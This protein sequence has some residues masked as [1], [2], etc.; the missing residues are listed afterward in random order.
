MGAKKYLGV[1]Y[2][3]LG[4]GLFMFTRLSNLVPFIGIAILIAPIFILRFIRTQPSKRGIW[5]TIL[6]FILSFNI[7]LWGLFE[8]DEKWMTIVFGLIRS[9]LLATIWFLPFIMDRMIYPRFKKRGAF[10]TLVF[11]VITTAIFYLS[12]LEG[13]FDDGSG[14]FSS[15][16]YDYRSLAFSQIRSVFGIWILVFIHS[17]LFSVI[18]YFW[19]NQF[20]LKNIRNAALTYSIVFL[21]IILFGVVKTSSKFSL[22]TDTVRIA[23]VVLIP[24]DGVVQPLSRYFEGKT[25]YPFEKGVKRIADLTQKAA[26]GD[27]KIVS[28]QEY[29]M[30]INKGDEM[31]LR[32][33]YRGIAR[34]NNI[35]LSITYAYFSEDEK[36]ENKHLFIDPRG[37]ILLDYTKRYLLGIG[38]F[39]EAGVFKKGPEVI[40]SVET[41]YGKIGITICR[42]M[43]FPSYI[44]QAARDNVDIMLSPSFD[45]PQSPAPWYHS[46]TI[47]N[48]FSFVRPAYNGYSYAADY[49]GKIL[50]HMESDRTADGIMY[51]N[52]PVKG[53]DVLYPVIGDLLGWLSLLGA[54]FLISLTLLD[55]KRVD[56]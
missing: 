12:S 53:I 31:R 34:E 9:T 49:N 28:F 36:G 6:G 22:K 48:G 40:Q 2:F 8:F 26:K 21:L 29:A 5:F 1:I 55:K 41:P 4:F 51:S 32:D 17:W 27:A 13:P 44:R 42:D 19:E 11:P 52:V 37:E 3:I 46:S 18:N 45:W 38:P 56:D 25:T 54:L 50:D 33:Y 16:S 24:E 15:F 39:G 20:R 30:L 47:E 23:A 10:S 14:T 7:A 43:G 35:Y